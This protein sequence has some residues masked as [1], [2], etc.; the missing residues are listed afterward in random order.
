MLNF[1]AVHFGEAF[2]RQREKLLYENF[3]ILFVHLG[4]GQMIEISINRHIL[5]SM[6]FITLSEV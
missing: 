4:L 5:C 6:F 1:M 2:F 3:N